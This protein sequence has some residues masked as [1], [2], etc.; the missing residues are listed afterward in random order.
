MSDLVLNKF[1]KVDPV[2]R[3]DRSENIFWRYGYCNL[4]LG[5]LWIWLFLTKWFEK[6]VEVK[7]F[8]VCTYINTPK[9]EVKCIK[10]FKT[11][12]LLNR[13]CVWLLNYS[14]EIVLM[15]H[16]CNL[17]FYLNRF[18]MYFMYFPRL[19]YHSLCNVRLEYNIKNIKY[20]QAHNVL[21]CLASQYFLK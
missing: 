4:R 9:F 18:Y 7:C 21:F 8:D 5:Y 16:F 6:F 19:E 11:L 2:I 17:K 20:I 15:A 10:T 14:S 13:E 3:I 1:H 12:C